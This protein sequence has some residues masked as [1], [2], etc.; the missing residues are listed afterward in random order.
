[1]RNIA[2]DLHRKYAVVAEKV[3]GSQEIKSSRFRLTPAGVQT[4]RKNV[5]ANCRIVMEAT[6]NAFWLHDQLCPVAGEVI[7]ANPA[8]LKAIAAARIKNDKL[9][10]AVMV[11]LLAADFIPRARA[12]GQAPR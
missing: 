7:L 6:G 3:D 9:D 4:F 12:S 11:Q 8:Q 1:L 10:A 5:D 2:I